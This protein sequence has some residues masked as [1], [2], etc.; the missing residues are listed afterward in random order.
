MALI[1]ILGLFMAVQ[2]N[3][4]VTIKLESFDKSMHF[5]TGIVLTNYKESS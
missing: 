2:A 1:L 5:H 3:K 4:L